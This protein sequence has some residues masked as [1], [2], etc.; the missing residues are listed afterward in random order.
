MKP[1][2]TQEHQ[3]IFLSLVTFV[4]GLFFLLI[5]IAFPQTHAFVEGFSHAGYPG[6]FVS[7]ILYSIAF[8]SSAAAVLLANIPEHFSPFLIAL[9][10]GLGSL[11]YDVT[12]F[13]LARRGRDGSFFQRFASRLP[14]PKQHIPKWFQTFLG[15]IVLGSPLPDEI[16]A[17]IM[18]LSSFS[19]SRFVVLSFLANTLGIYLLLV[20]T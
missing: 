10:G 3:H 4:L 12:I 14:H 8:T 13:T 5:A 20:I 1:V 6:A 17:S 9:L 7:G 2:K 18:G 11:L 19:T 16:A 15:F